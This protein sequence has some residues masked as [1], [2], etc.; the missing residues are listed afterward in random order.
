MS[1][2]ESQYYH[3]RIYKNITGYTLTAFICVILVAGVFAMLTRTGSAYSAIDSDGYIT[4]PEDAEP[5]Y[6]YTIGQIKYEVYNTDDGDILYAYKDD[7]LTGVNTGIGVPPEGYSIVG[8]KAGEGVTQISANAYQNNTT[9]QYLDM[10]ECTT[11]TTI[12]GGAFDNTP[13]KSVV[14]S[15]DNNITSIATYA[16]RNCSQLESFPFEKL[17]KITSLG[18]G[19]F[20]SCSSLPEVNLSNSTELTSL[21]TNCF[22]DCANLTKA[23]LSACTL[24]PSIPQA[25]YKGCSNLSTVLLPD[26]NNISS[27]GANT[28]SGCSQ[29]ESFPFDKLTELTSL[30]ENCF[31]SCSNLA[32]ADLSQCNKLTYLG[33]F[34]F[35]SCG[36]LTKVDLRGCT[37]IKSI[38]SYAFRSCSKLSTVLLPNDNNITLIG[39]AAFQKCSNLESFPFEKLT[40]LT[41]LGVNC[42]HSCINL[43]KADLSGCTL[44]TSIPD[45]TF[46]N[47]SKLSTVLLPEDNNIVGIGYSAFSDCSQLESFPFEKLTKI[48]SMKD[49]AFN[50]CSKL[51]K[52]DLSKCT[53]LKTFGKGCFQLCS[54]LT[55][56]DLSGCTILTSISDNMFQQC[57]KLSTVLLPEDNNITGIEGQAF[58][59][60]TA[61]E[62]FPFEK[63]T[64]LNS[65]NLG[66]FCYS[67]LVEINLKNTQVTVINK[68]VFSRCVNLKKV[69]LN[70][71]TTR[72]C[73]NAFDTNVYNGKLTEFNAE[74][75]NSLTQ[76][77]NAAFRGQ[78]GLHLHFSDENTLTYLGTQVWGLYENNS[79][80]FSNLYKLETIDANCF[81]PYN[82]GPANLDLTNCISLKTIGTNA[83]AGDTNGTYPTIVNVSGSG[84][85]SLETIGTGAF[86][87]SRTLASVDFSGCTSLNSVG[88]FYLSGY[89][90]KSPTALKSVNFSGCTSL[91]SIPNTFVYGATALTTADFSNCD[92]L[93]TVGSQAFY[94]CT[95]LSNLL[96]S[97]NIETIGEQAFYN[98]KSLK[99]ITLQAPLTCV[100]AQAFYGTNALETIHYDAVNL[101]SVEPGTFGN[102]S[103]KTKVS[104]YIDDAVDYIA[105]N[106]LNSTVNIGTVYFA[107]PNDSLFIGAD[108]FKAAGLPLSAMSDGTTE[109]CVDEYGVVYSKDMSTLYYVPPGI[110]SY[111]VPDS[112]TTVKSY[113]LKH[114]SDLATL[115]FAD[116]E[117]IT[118]LA[119][120]AF[121]DCVTLTTISDGNNSTNLLSEARAMFVNATIGNYAFENTGL[122]DDIDSQSGL[123]KSPIVHKTMIDEDT[124]EYVL[125]T[126]FKGTAGEILTDINPATKRIPSVENVN[127]NIFYYLTNDIATVNINL[128]ATAATESKVCRVYFKTSSDNIEFEL[129]EGK[130]NSISTEDGQTFDCAFNRI[131]GTN[132]YYM[133]FAAN[134]GSTL[135]FSTTLYYPNLSVNSG[136]VT[137]WSEIVNSTDAKLKLTPDSYQKAQWYTAAQKWSVTKGGNITLQAL[138]AVKKDGV[139]TKRI[140]S[141]LSYTITSTSTYGT[142]GDTSDT[143]G[144]DPVEYI[145][146][147]DTISLPAGI[148]WEDKVVEAVRNGDYSTALSNTTRTI[149]VTI[150]GQ[151]MVFATISNSPSEVELVVNED[152]TISVIFKKYNTKLDANTTTSNK[153]ELDNLSFVIVFNADEIFIVGD[154]YDI[155]K[156][157][158]IKNN[159]TQ[160]EK[161]LYAVQDMTSLHTEDMFLQ[162]AS[163]GTNV[164]ISSNPRTVIWKDIDIAPAYG[165]YHVYGGAKANFTLSVTNDGVVDHTKTKVTD[166]LP[167]IYKITPDDMEEMFHD[168]VNGEDLQIVISKAYKQ[169]RTITDVTDTQG[170]TRELEPIDQGVELSDSDLISTITIQWAPDKTYIQMDADGEK[171]TVGQGQEYSS[172]M[173]AFNDIGILNVWS[174]IYKV[175]WLFGEEKQVTHPGDKYIYNI[176]ATAKTTFEKITEDKLTDAY[177]G[178][179]TTYETGY[180]N[181]GYVYF[182][183]DYSSGR[184]QRMPHSCSWD[185]EVRLTQ[186]LSVNG[187]TIDNSNNSLNVDD[188]LD[189]TTTI[190]KYGNGVEETVPLNNEITGMQALL[191]PVDSNEEAYLETTLGNVKLSDL[192]LATYTDSDNHTYYI[193]S[194]NGTYRNVK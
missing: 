154:D 92:A 61:L 99:E 119:D 35:E 177:G 147:T 186:S 64:K 152:N 159:V 193:L 88:S 81:A 150:D 83:F 146:Y 20:M 140:Y 101:A 96:L 111:T 121:E 52:V 171:H 156:A 24:I 155:T 16:F 36:S 40:E 164:P 168:E 54:S 113:A 153:W 9:I 170:N 174:T 50:R 158:T 58:Y 132:I 167:Q 124:D 192:G 189:Y 46:Q 53:E 39:S 151:K 115:T 84:L 105:D 25:A 15:D 11:V 87:A 142:N 74:E 184:S 98:C 73:Q 66:A 17:T 126:F 62:S 162:S 4:I 183:A 123:T 49:Y 145:T 48:T 133:E 139:V 33:Q 181:T 160:E 37:L 180:Y 112:V 78:T 44:L 91:A 138:K 118:T 163:V 75:L 106:F 128:S 14:I 38:P 1:R 72:I 63:L 32:E 144:Q 114:A 194:E 12:G 108:A 51:E 116:I 45:G 57:S 7:S 122:I 179:G 103:Q 68:Q 135:G 34:S 65:I 55:K 149:Y 141:D 157:S 94:N 178:N 120:S 13:L 117:G 148:V 5:V 70:V 191:V 76:I 182:N 47:C 187:V 165:I 127:E 80:D 27:I 175:N 166:P 110:T 28:F 79:I 169:K 176:K 188:V 85:P 102:T 67:G 107:G 60:C 173:E 86:S 8:L 109:Y 2:V 185:R 125:S 77:D 19:A 23:D 161:Y 42:F 21:G 41:T 89:N 56:A 136:Y 59:C 31:F 10:S 3:N 43:T 190:T 97:D 100:G 22:L 82:K 172:L 95:A 26:D 93:T 71:N 69:A 134:P 130:N 29:L 129:V 6:T 90:L 143:A 137:L 18:L 30:G 104:V 131:A